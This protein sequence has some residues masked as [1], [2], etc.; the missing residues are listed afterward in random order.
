[1]LRQRVITALM[2]AGAFIA[3]LLFAPYPVQ[4]V[5]FAAVA[6]A[7][8]WEWSAL[9]GA[10]ST[11]ARLAYTAVIPLL[12]WGLWVVLEM[13]GAQSAAAA[14]PLLAVSALLWSA[15][16]LGLKYYP[17]GRGVWSQA[18]IRALMGWAMLTPTP[19]GCGYQP[20]EN[21]G[22]FL[23]RPAL[24]DAIGDIGMAQLASV[25]ITSGM[26]VAA[27][28]GSRYGRC[29]CGGRSHGQL[30]KARGRSQRFWVSVAGSRRPA[31]SSRQYLW[32]SAGLCTGSSV[33]RVLNN[34][35]GSCVGRDGFYW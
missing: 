18:S 9:S 12:C 22:G 26:G 19:I 20:G 1:M 7:G 24:C 17:A 33:G 4:C 14:Q 5:L 2:L 29:V 3:T 6:S 23:G 8:A 35:S 28:L 10:R 13:D 30:A 27:G 34:A 11:P 25:A 16:L 21:V 31:G 15:M 32:R